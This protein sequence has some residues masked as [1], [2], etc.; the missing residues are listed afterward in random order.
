M[1]FTPKSLS[2]TTTIV[3]L[4]ISALLNQQNVLIIQRALRR[5]DNPPVRHPRDALNATV[6]L[7]PRVNV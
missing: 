1:A 2:F 3:L 7:A 4:S 5:R 6:R